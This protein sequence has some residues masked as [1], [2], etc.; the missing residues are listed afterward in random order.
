MRTQFNS[1]PYGCYV[2]DDSTVIF[3]RTYKP[4]VRMQGAWPNHDPASAEM[5]SLK[6]KAFAPRPIYFYQSDNDPCFDIKKR[7]WL[8]DLIHSIP[9]LSDVI[10]LR[11]ASRD[12]DAIYYAFS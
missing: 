12:K 6:D 10:E 5:V 1:S 4:I 3:D 8:R 2:T 7:V 9:V 11:V